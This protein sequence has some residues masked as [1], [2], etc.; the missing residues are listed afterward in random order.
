MDVA[1][2]AHRHL[3][4]GIAMLMA[5]VLGVPLVAIPAAA[6]IVQLRATAPRHRRA[7]ADLA[8]GGRHARR[9]PTR[10]PRGSERLAEGLYAGGDG[11]GLPVTMRLARATFAVCCMS[12]LM[13]PESWAFCPAVLGACRLAN[14]AH[15]STR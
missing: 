4:L 7:D 6:R 15:T 1:F 5:A 10:A 11:A 13:K 3:P 2:G 14:S 9:W 12:R 8:A